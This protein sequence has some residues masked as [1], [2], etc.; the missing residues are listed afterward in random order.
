MTVDRGFTSMPCSQTSLIVMAYSLNSSPVPP[1]RPWKRLEPVSAD[2]LTWSEWQGLLGAVCQV[3]TLPS[4][5]EM[6]SSGQQ[7]RPAST[8]FGLATHAY[9]DSLPAAAAIQMAVLL[10]LKLRSPD[11]MPSAKV[12]ASL[13]SRSNISCQSEL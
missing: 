10:N 5:S 13:W 4:P 12:A 7:Q 3:S 9:S 8:Q 2:T 11:L 1:W 6:I